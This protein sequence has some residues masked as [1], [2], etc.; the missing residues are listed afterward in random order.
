MIAV[1]GMFLFSF[2]TIVSAEDKIGV[3]KPNVEFNITNF[4]STADCTYMD[5]ESVTY[6]NGTVLFLGDAMNQVGQ[7]FTYNFSSE[8]SGTYYFRT[9]ADPRGSEMCERDYF[10]INPAGAAFTIA[11]AILYGFILVLLGLF[12]F[13]SIHGVRKAVSAEWLIGYICLSYL[14]LYLIVSVLW[15][16][17]KN[18]IIGFPMLESVLFMAWFVMG[19]GFLPFIIIVSLYILGKEAKAT[20][21]QGYT[22][23]GYSREEAKELSRKN[24]R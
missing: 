12:L 17:T 7:E 11:Q 23:Q 21:E 9:C 18:Y 22:K 8:D 10:S 6:P 5:L 16:L 14:V 15:I 19:I 24:K 4:C 20:L 1:L 3:F 13:L 2:A